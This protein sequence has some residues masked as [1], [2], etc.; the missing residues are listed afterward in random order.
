[1]CTFAPCGL[2]AVQED[3]P[4]DG[5][6]LKCN[7]NTDPAEC[8]P[9]KIKYLTSHEFQYKI[10]LVPLNGHISSAQ[11]ISP[12]LKFTSVSLL[13]FKKNKQKLLDVHGG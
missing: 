1:M 12:G 10:L 7:M 9:F 3:H 6:V 11:L 2:G 13:A 5:A 8:L 4:A